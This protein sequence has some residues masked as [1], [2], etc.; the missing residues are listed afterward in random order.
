MIEQNRGSIRLGRRLFNVPSL[1]PGAA[2]MLLLISASLVYGALHASDYGQSTDDPGDAAYGEVTLR[3]YA[4]A[5]GYDGPTDRKF[6]GPLYWMVTSFASSALES[7][8]PSLPAVDVRHFLNFAA[9]QV[10]LVAFYSLS[11]RLVAAGPALLSTLLF[12]FQPVFFGHAFINQKDV[13]LMAAF[14]VAMALGVR[15][16]DRQAVSA[17]S[18]LGADGATPLP[19]ALARGWSRS[20][21]L[22]RAATVLAIAIALLVWIDVFWGHQFAAFAHSGLASLYRG[23]AFEPLQAVFDSLAQD[24]YK[25]PLA[26]YAGKLNVIL[27]WLGFAGACLVTLPAIALGASVSR[28]GGSPGLSRFLRVVL[29]AALAL[30][31]AL[32]I[33]VSAGFAGLLV[34]LFLLWK[35]R[36]SSLP[37]LAAYWIIAFSLCY[38]TWPY[39]WGDPIRRFVT[40]TRVMTSFGD[41]YG[42]FRGVV[43]P[44][45]DLPWDYLPTLLSIQLTEPAILLA[46]TGLATLVPISR[47]AGEKRSFVAVI[48]L[49]FFVPLLASMIGRVPMYNNFR[50]VLFAL[51]PIFLTAGLG[52]SFVWRYLRRTVW[53]VAFGGLILLPG[54]VAIAR[55]RPYEYIYYN[56]L[57]GGNKSAEGQFA[58][59]YWC[60]SVREAMDYINKEA[61]AGAL[62]AIQDPFQVAKTFARPDLQLLHTRHHPKAFTIHCNDR[63]DLNSE[64][65]GQ[66]PVQHVITRAGAILSVVW[67]PDSPSDG[68][69]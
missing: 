11:R 67:G 5:A 25:T 47:L 52:I 14:L 20:P 41:R 33:R 64:N 37:G 35:E 10:G 48:L 2:G 40:A 63:G 38:L 12:A 59:D 19:K 28:R 15:M 69:P 31:V 21:R 8:V 23:E 24:R 39:L 29:P 26:G 58:Q 22:L 56:S 3:A 53:V 45:T 1:G 16:A 68:I 55:L 65:L 61:P 30:G 7:A 17:A 51:P 36:R 4:G 66:F 57:V 50:Q 18:P 54:L 32:S 34:S 27:L 44:S 62:V 60:T 46:L 42:L 13:P 9:F 43:L 6:Y 49:W